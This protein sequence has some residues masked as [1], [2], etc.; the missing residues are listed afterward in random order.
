[1]DFFDRIELGGKG[2]KA[3][4]E[5]AAQALS[6]LGTAIADAPDAS[7]LEVRTYAHLY[8]HRVEKAK[9]AYSK[10][11][12]SMA[13]DDAAGCIE[14]AE[15][16]LLHLQLAQLH[17]KTEV[18]QM[19]A[20]EAGAP[21]FSPGGSEE[22]ILQLADAICRIKMLAEYKSMVLSKELRRHLSGTVQNLQDAIESYGNGDFRNAF[23]TAL[24]GIIWCQYIHARLGGDAL[25]SPKH[26]TK[27]IRALYQLAWDLGLAA[28]DP[29]CRQTK[30]GRKKL[31]A[32]EDYLQSAMNGYFEDDLPEMERFVR[33]GG[34][35]ATALTRLVARVKTKDLV[36]AMQAGS[37]GDRAPRQSLKQLIAEMRELLDRHHPHPDRALVALEALQY[38]VALLRR[39]L[40]AEDWKETKRAIELCRYETET[41]SKEVKKLT[42]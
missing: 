7:D 2:K 33:L 29:I 28:S 27:A 20:A 11:M 26:Q 12:K 34:I 10:A 41:L 5:K 32:L 25:F 15:R 9:R 18:S 35:E 14:H 8:G 37:L 30:D 23:D 38:N 3:G 24:G 19:T 21:N 1:L 16:G 13:D 22:S 42:E 17:G 6:K 36:S 31:N 4:G 40:R 39:G